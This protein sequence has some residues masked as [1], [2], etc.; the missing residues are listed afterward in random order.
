MARPHPGFLTEQVLAGCENLRPQVPRGC[1][2]M[3]RATG[4]EGR[5]AEVML[6]VVPGGRGD[7]SVKWADLVLSGVTRGS[8]GRVLPSVPAGGGNPTPVT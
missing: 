6:G 3:V 7:L 8:L 2:S 5:G 1:Y 4:V